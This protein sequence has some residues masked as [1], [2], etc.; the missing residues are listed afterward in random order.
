MLERVINSGRGNALQL[1]DARRLSFDPH[2]CGPLSFS[3]LN[4][5]DIVVEILCWK[6]RHVKAAQAFAWSLPFPPFFSAF[7]TTVI[8]QA[9]RDLLLYE[10]DM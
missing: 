9:G 10:E 2:P 5:Q 1:F 7:T 8:W 6:L 3:P 4:D